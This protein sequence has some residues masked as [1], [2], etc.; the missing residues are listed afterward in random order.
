MCLHINFSD[1]YSPWENVL[2]DISRH[3]PSELIHSKYRTLAII[4]SGWYCFERG[5]RGLYCSEAATDQERRL[6]IQD[7][8]EEAKVQIA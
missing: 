2:R 8:H 3:K 4:R 7:A 6:L 1:L 5:R